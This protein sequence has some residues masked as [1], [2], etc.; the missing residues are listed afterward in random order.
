M[1]VTDFVPNEVRTR[2]TL[3]HVLVGSMIVVGGLMLVGSFSFVREA[4]LFPRFAAIVTIIGSVLLLVQNYLPERLNR[5]ISS[6]VDVF[7]ETE[8]ELSESV[9]SDREESADEASSDTGQT[10]P[11]QFMTLLLLGFALCSYLVGMLWTIPIF[12]ATYAWR[13]DITRKRTALLALVG[14]GIGLAFQLVLDIPIDT[15]LIFEMVTSRW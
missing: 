1:A 9:G 10:A 14:F 11:T 4:Y 15:G 8:K 7:G 3:R 6:S 2:F 12:I 5:A 13:F